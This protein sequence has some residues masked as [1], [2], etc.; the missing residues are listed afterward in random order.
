MN[1]FSRAR[2]SGSVY[3]ACGA[4]VA[5]SL[6]VGCSSPRRFGS[7]ALTPSAVSS[8]APAARPRASLRAIRP[9]PPPLPP[10]YPDETRAGAPWSGMQLAMQPSPQGVLVG[11]VSMGSPAELAGI[12]PGDFIFQLDGQLVSDAQEILSQVERVGVGGSVR[13]GVHRNERVRLFRVAPVA[14]PVPASAQ[15]SDPELPSATLEGKPP[16]AN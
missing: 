16:P 5:L 12:Q 3:V 10:I 1:G 6:I 7:S 15:T 9:A 2:S 13:L 14:K 4:C 11:V 8:G